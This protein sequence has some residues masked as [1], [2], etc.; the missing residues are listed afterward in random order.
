M[1]QTT[2]TMNFSV[3]ICVNVSGNSDGYK[4]RRLHIFMLNLSAILYFTI[5][6][7]VFFMI[8]RSSSSSSSLV[9]YLPFLN[10]FPLLSNALAK[11]YRTKQKKTDVF[12]AI[13][14]LLLVLMAFL[15]EN[16]YGVAFGMSYFFGYF[17]IGESGYFLDTEVPSVD[18]FQYL[19][20]FLHYFAGKT[21]CY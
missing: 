3:I 1:Y 9:L 17:F 12:I 8:G 11:D 6:E 19:T 10:V 5:I 2:G 18:A 20:C 7:G 15:D 13:N 16:Y 21:L 4:L 14:S